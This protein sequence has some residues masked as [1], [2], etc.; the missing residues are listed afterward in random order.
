MGLASLCT[1]L[2][3]AQ[4]P[5]T[6]PWEP[7][8][9]AISEQVLHEMPTP[10]LVDEN[11]PWSGEGGVT[12]HHEDVLQDPVQWLTRETDPLFRSPPTQ[13]SFSHLPRW[14]RS[15]FGIQTFD[16][17]HTV[18]LGYDDLA[19]LH[20]TPGFAFHGWSGPAELD[21]PSRVFDAYL[22]LFWQPWITERGSI[23]VGA[24]PGFHGD[25][26]RF[27]RQTFQW[28]GWLA[29]TWRLNDRWMAMGGV[30]YLRQL[31]SNWLPIG[32]AVWTPNE[33][34]RLELIFPSPRIARQIFADE[35]GSTWAYVA[36]NFGGGA[37]SVADTP[38]SNVLVGYSDLRLLVGVEGFRFHGYEWR[39]EMGYVFSRDI[40]VNNISLVSPSDSMVFQCRLAF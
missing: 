36:G 23:L 35:R 22:D 12:P 2:L 25:F 31:R 26:E 19:P 9:S 29:G 1:L 32:G 38:T 21:L 15:G 28:S 6:E 5:P 16:V 34:T 20:I 3:V 40:H 4:L 39:A 37:W 27:D 11:G 30:A 24:T 17:R 14:D 18:L 8:D 7:P 33:L 13:L 10:S